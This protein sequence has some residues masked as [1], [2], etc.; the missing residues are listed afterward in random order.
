MKTLLNILVI[1]LIGSVSYAQKNNAFYDAS[2]LRE[3]AKNG[4]IVASKDVLQVLYNYESYGREVVDASTV[5]QAYQDNPFIAPYLVGKPGSGDGSNEK[6]V[7]LTYGQRGVVSDAPKA[8][9]GLALSPSTLLL[10]LAD[11]LVQ[12][13][14]QE[15][16]IAF[17]KE[18]NKQVK[19][20][21]ELRILFPQT[22][23]TLIAIEEDIYR[24]TAF[25]EA[26]RE[27]FMEDLGRLPE[28]LADYF[29]ESEKVK[30]PKVRALAG[31][32]FEVIDMLKRKNSPTDVIQYL[33]RGALFQEMKFEDKSMQQIQ[34]NL[35][36][37]GLFSEGLEYMDDSKYW[38]SPEK[39][40]NLLRDSMQADLFLGL[41]YQ[42]GKDLSLGEQ[43]MGQH[44]VSM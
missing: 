2:A 22:K 26:I 34:N 29:Q 16:H 7:R 8:S 6:I 18:F 12:R 32:C 9:N 25:W 27:S 3:K 4:K 17:F 30:D 35:K 15:L 20:S 39:F 44:M 28:H 14:K 36:L 42:K 41:I 23:E 1:I 5:Q 19:K 33:S 38:V 43:T 13:T 21:E 40:N 11:F 24:F 31:D 10:G 37:V